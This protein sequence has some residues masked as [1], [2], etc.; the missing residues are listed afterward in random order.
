MKPQVSPTSQEQ[1]ASLMEP[2]IIHN[3]PVKL[4]ADE[5]KKNAPEPPKQFLEQGKHEQDMDD[6]VLN[7]VNKAVKSSS[8]KNPKR[9]L[10]SFRKKPHKEEVDN[11]PKPIPRQNPKSA[12]PKP[13]VAVAGASIMAI[14]LCAI[15]VYAFTLNETPTNSTAKTPS[16]ASSPKASANNVASSK[17]SSLDLK[18]IS[19]DLESKIDA[20]DDSQDF[21]TSA[22][23]DSSLGLQ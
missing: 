9:P 7:D 3:I 5:I 15:A 11:K 1:K 14:T 17:V 10:F 6:K 20:L 16:S 22:L 4:H 8:E 12:N 18:R 21:S 23:S 13:L 19:S 2:E